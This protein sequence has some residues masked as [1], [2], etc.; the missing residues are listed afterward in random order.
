[1]FDVGNRRDPSVCECPDGTW[2][3]GSAIC[4]DCAD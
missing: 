1:V 3:D 4:P 2:D